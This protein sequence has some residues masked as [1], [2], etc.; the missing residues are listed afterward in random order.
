MKEKL[1]SKGH[2]HT[3]EEGMKE[4]YTSTTIITDSESSLGS[5]RAHCKIVRQQPTNKR[6]QKKK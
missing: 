1:A 5:E 6:K 3:Q 4:K 2:T